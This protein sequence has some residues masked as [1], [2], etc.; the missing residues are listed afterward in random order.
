MLDELQSLGMGESFERQFIAQCLSDARDCI[1]ALAQSLEQGDS[2]QMREHAHALKGVSSN[3]GL[4]ALAATSGEMM[5]LPELQITR[6][7]KQRVAGLNARL[8]EG[9]LA[10]DARDQ[11]R[12]PTR[13]TGEIS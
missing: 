2:A 5:R 4:A 11:A 9:R 10:L 12:R 8:E 3:L 13:D 1:V 7:W 6:D